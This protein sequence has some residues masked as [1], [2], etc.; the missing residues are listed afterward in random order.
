MPVEIQIGYGTRV[1]ATNRIFAQGQVTAM[2]LG[3]SETGLVEIRISG[4]DEDL[5]MEKA[6]DLLAAFRAI[7]GTIHLKQD[8]ENRVLKVEVLVDQN[9]ARR[10]GVTSE[11]IASSLNA[12][13]SGGAITDYR[14]GDAVIPVI[15]RGV[16]GERDQL[17]N[18]F[19]INVFSSANG[20]SVP[21]TQIADIES[22]WEPYSIGRRN[23]ETLLGPQAE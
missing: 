9:R 22:T 10:A 17:S 8:W 4:P 5:L 2:W 13:V 15:L 19:S 20:S 23:L 1:V 3:P 21:L 12:F 11:D 7:P 16:A 14:E 6:Q 18:L